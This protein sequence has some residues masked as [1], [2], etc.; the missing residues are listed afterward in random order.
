MPDID[1]RLTHQQAE[2]I[3][4]LIND[5]RDSQDI[6]NQLVAILNESGCNE[7]TIAQI[8]SDGNIINDAC[9]KFKDYKS[10]YVPNI[11]R[12]AVWDTIIEHK[13]IILPESEPENKPE[14]SKRFEFFSRKKKKSDESQW[15]DTIDD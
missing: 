3:T 6:T 2:D 1:I 14:K 13:I 5:C 9:C 11:M 7:Q 10:L 8:I 15:N 12:Q 4:D